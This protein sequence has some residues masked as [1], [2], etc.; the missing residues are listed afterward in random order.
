MH[1]EPYGASD[2]YR[3]VR[4][5]MRSLFGLSGTDSA[6]LGEQLRVTVTNTAP[7]LEPFLPLLGNALQ[8]ALPSTVESDSISAQFR[9]DRTAAVVLELIAARPDGVRHPVASL[10]ADLVASRRRWWFRH[11]VG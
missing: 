10:A 1:A 7:Q 3:V 11:R 2:S 9:A 6:A 8:L 5:P 4:E